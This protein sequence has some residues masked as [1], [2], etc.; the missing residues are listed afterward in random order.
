MVISTEGQ[1]LDLLHI[2]YAITARYKISNCYVFKR[3]WESDFLV[4]LRG[5]GW[6]H[7]HEVKLSRADYFADFKKQKHQILKFG[8][9]GKSKRKNIRPNRFSF[10]VPEGLIKKTEVPDYAGL[11]YVKY[12]TTSGEW[13]TWVVKRAPALHNLK[14]DYDKILCKKFYWYWQRARECCVRLSNNIEAI[15]HNQV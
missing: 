4:I 14:L 1:I 8:H 7:E 9:Y 3:N 6:S 15:K 10:V 13:K 5:T 2:K 11:M 12:D